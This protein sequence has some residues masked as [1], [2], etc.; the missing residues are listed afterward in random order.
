MSTARS[1]RTSATS[2]L[3]IGGLWERHEEGDEEW[4]YD[5]FLH[6]AKHI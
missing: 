1:S 2:R 5:E 3:G 6:M 4:E